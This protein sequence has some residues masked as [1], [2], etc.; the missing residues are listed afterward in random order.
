MD[1]DIV[2]NNKNPNFLL[3][4]D[5]DR[6]KLKLNDENGYSYIIPFEEKSLNNDCQETNINANFK[7]QIKDIALIVQQ[8]QSTGKLGPKGCDGRRGLKGDTGLRGIEGPPGPG[9]RI[10]FTVKSKENL[11]LNDVAEN[12]ITLTER[13]S[14]RMFDFIS[15]PDSL[16]S[17]LSAA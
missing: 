6:K 16:S 11:Q 14:G 15:S 13:F 5:S 2:N 1:K 3:S 17:C 10:T 9:L 8:I 7:K 12:D 4:F